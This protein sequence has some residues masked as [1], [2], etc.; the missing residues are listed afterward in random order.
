[1]YHST[2]TRRLSRD[3]VRDRVGR[4]NQKS[5][6]RRR[7]D[8]GAIGREGECLPRVHQLRGT[9]QAPTDRGDVRAPVQGDERLRAG[10]ARSIIE[11]MNKSGS[12]VR[13]GADAEE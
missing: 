10:R 5:P 4:R 7:T 1:M 3:T 13:K 11:E 2:L 6:P 12:S 8:A 9:G